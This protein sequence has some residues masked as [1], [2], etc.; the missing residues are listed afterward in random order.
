MSILYTKLH[1]ILS[2]MVSNMMYNFEKYYS[3]YH[4]VVCNMEQYIV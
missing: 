3:I 1:A 4:Q 2:N